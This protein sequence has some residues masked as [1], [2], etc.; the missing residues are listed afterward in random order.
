MD[1]NRPASERLES[2]GGHMAPSRQKNRTSKRAGKQP[3][4]NRRSPSSD[5]GVTSESNRYGLTA[6]VGRTRSSLGELH[7]WISTP[8]GALRILGLCGPCSESLDFHLRSFV[9]VEPQKDGTCLFSL[10]ALLSLRRKWSPCNPCWD[11][12]I[13]AKHSISCVCSHCLK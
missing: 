6:G 9:T 8:A 3:G 11:R 5:Q 7:F 13:D 12:I 4:R 1:R 10:D 2:E